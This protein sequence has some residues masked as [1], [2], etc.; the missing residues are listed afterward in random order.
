MGQKRALISVFDKSNVAGLARDLA[1]LGWE[2]VSSS[3][4]ARHIRESGVPVKEVEDLTGYPHMLGGRVK[5]LHPS[6]FGG[7]LARRHFEGDLIDVEKF[8][9]PM[10]DMVVC[11]LYPFEE[12]FNQGADLDEL[13]ENIDIGGVTLI[14][15]AAKNFRHVIP[16]TDPEDY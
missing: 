2:I 9:I 5:T 10:I 4:T 3:G 11:N 13:L 7:I 15:A 1:D 8:G 14:R 16:V 12:T 6:V